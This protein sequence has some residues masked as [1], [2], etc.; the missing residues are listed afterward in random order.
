MYFERG[1]EGRGRE[2]HTAKV[3]IQDIR[4]AKK[5]NVA[6]SHAIVRGLRSRGMGWFGA[7]VGRA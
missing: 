1:W 5:S 6:V 3:R 4:T 2:S 7:G